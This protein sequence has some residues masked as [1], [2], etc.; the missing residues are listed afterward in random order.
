M[1]IL[2]ATP[3]DMPFLSKTEKSTYLLELEEDWSGENQLHVFSWVEVWSV[4]TDAPHVIIL[5]FSS[6]FSGLMV[7]CSS[8]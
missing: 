1:L 8:E 7:R 6:F 5:C 4:V 3:A 2:P